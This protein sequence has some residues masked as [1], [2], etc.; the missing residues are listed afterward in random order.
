MIKKITSSTAVMILLISLAVVNAIWL[1]VNW[2]GGPLIALAFYLVASV[3]C[4]KKQHFQA[5]AFAGIIGFGIHLFELIGSGTS[6]LT[7][8]T[9]I[10]FYMNLILPILLSITSYLASR[11]GSGE[12]TD[13]NKS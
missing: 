8:I 3:L 11:R 4:L 10:L 9:E 7:G 1:I 6:R 12:L 5:G 2:H 13:Q